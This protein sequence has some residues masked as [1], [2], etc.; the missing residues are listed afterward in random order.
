MPG[1]KK[2]VTYSFRVLTVALA[3]VFFQ[4]SSDEW[5]G[6][7]H[8]VTKRSPDAADRA[9]ERRICTRPDSSCWRVRIVFRAGKGSAQ[10]VCYNLSVTVKQYSGV[11]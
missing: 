10:Y 3:S 9:K 1:N 6:K 8:S 2:T 11:Q 4:D 7:T 5:S